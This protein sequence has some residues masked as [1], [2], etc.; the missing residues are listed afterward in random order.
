MA[1]DGIGHAASHGLKEALHLTRFAFG[2]Q[3][4]LAAGQIAHAAGDGEPVGETTGGVTEADA[5]HL[6]GVEDALADK[7]GYIPASTRRRLAAV[8]RTALGARF[9]EPRRNEFPKPWRVTA[10]LPVRRRRRQGSRR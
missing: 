2:D 4:H 6:A 5:L 3:F 9:Y 10:C 1:V 7:H 8:R